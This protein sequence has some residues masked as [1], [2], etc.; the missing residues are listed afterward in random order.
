MKLLGILFF[1]FT[2]KVPFS[3]KL[4]GLKICRLFLILGGK[5]FEVDDGLKSGA[6]G[7]H[8]TL[9]FL[10]SEALQIFTAASFTAACLWVFVP[11][12]LSEVKEKQLS[13][14][15]ISWLTR[16]LKNIPCV[17][18]QRL[19]AFSHRYL[20]SLSI[21]TVKLRPV[22]SAAFG[23]MWADSETLNMSEFILPFLSA[24]TWSTNSS[25]PVSLAATHAHAMTLPPPR[26]TDDALCFGS[27]AVPFPLHTFLFTRESCFT[28]PKNLLPELSRC[29]QMFPVRVSSDLP[30]LQ[31]LQLLARCYKPSVFRLLEASLACELWQWSFT[32]SR[33]SFTCVDVLKGFSSPKT[34]SSFGVFWA[35]PDV[36]VLVS[37]MVLS[38]FFR[39]WHIVDL[40]TDEVSICLTG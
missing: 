10:P 3:D 18:L 5:S 33:G 14:L 31:C 30:V 11:S 35:L 1:V 12:V 39:L 36:L 2:H 9:S 8:Q 27:P 32:S 21:C 37:L 25:E 16:S 38:L 23:W 7:R 15:Q 28:C 26:W 20:G 4:T 34:S 13:W 6:R 19:F 24:V 29:F 22:S 40:V 17:C